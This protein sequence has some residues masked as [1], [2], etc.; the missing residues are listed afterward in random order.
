MT[1]LL[2][3]PRLPALSMRHTGRGA[4]AERTGGGE[5]AADAPLTGVAA[6][7]SIAR[8]RSHHG[9]PAPGVA[10]RWAGCHPDSLT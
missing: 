4:Q 8:L 6:A 5:R 3:G 9:N 1:R 2:C 7:L 10:V